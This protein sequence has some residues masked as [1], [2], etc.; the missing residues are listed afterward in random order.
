MAG[1]T[2]GALGSDSHGDHFRPDLEGLRAVAVLLVLLYH[3][4]VPGFGGGFVGVDVFFVL[5]GFLITSLLLRELHSTGT[6][7]IAGFYAR[8]ARRLLPAAGLVLIVTLVGSVVFLSPL[9]IPTVSADIGAAGLYVSNFRFAAQANDYFAAGG[10]PSPVLHYWSL[11]VEEQF[12]IVWP[13][14]L[15]LLYRWGRSWIGIAVGVIVVASFGLSLVLTGVNQ[16]V[17]FYLLPTR[18]WQLGVGAL[19]SLAA[20]RFTRI[21]PALGATLTLLGVVAAAAASLAFSDRTPFPG[22]AA[23]L[24]VAA[25]ALVIV[26]GMPSGGTVASRWLAV[27]PV[28]YL[29]TI[30]Y[31]VYL[32]HWPLL[33]LAAGA[34]GHALSPRAENRGRSDVDPDRGGDPA[35]G[36]GA[37]PT[38]SPHRRGTSPEPRPGGASER[39]DRCGVCPRGASAATARWQCGGGQ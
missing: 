4:G 18:A 3:A 33:V 19:L 27:R 31:S 10:T 7:S 28:R 23:A 9:R 22:M 8:R 29:G 35:A 15:L 26:G 14:L 1:M 32:W 24:P 5:S 16:P 12:Y 20:L 36:R 2:G 11:S 30:S 37:A 13:G 39:S 6:L 34:V 25:A 17:A 21:N 38:R